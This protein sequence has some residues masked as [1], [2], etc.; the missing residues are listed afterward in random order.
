[1]HE[2]LGIIRSV[3]HEGDF[4]GQLF[5]VSRFL[6]HHKMGLIVKGPFSC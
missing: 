4:V 6:S 5:K 2:L 3:I 1:M